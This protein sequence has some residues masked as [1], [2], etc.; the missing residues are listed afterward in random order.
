MPLSSEIAACLCSDDSATTAELQSDAST[1][2]LVERNL[3]Y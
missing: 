1:L 3:E 2:P